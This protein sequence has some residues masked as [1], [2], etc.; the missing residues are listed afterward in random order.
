MRQTIIVI[1]L[2]TTV[3]SVCG[4]EFNTPWIFAPQSDSTSHVY[5]RKSFLS[6]GRP[7]QVALK[8]TTTGYYKL[9]VNECNVGTALFYPHRDGN[10]T[11]AIETTFDITTYLRK[12]TNV[13]AILYSPIYPKLTT[14]QIAVNIY[15]KDCN[16]K[17]FCFISDESWLCRQANSHITPD[18]GEF[19][20][21][22]GHDPSWKAT[23]IY[24]QAL[25]MHAQH[26]NNTHKAMPIHYSEY[27]P[28]ITRVTTFNT[29]DISLTED[30]ITALELPYG[31]YGF[32]RATIREAKRG[33]EIDLGNLHYICNG[34]TDEQ[35]FPQFTINFLRTLPITG[36]DRFKASHIVDLEAISVAQKNNKIR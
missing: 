16:G 11:A 27:S 26:I 36:D 13:I 22:R 29:D 21:G 32:Y 14:K 7:K 33:E 35:A 30:S 17:A 34:K 18:G 1:L 24:N 15:G 28:H 4:Q 12:D 31:F 9:Y 8:F 20:D 23:T 10:D 6:D 3:L 2:F 5:F 19:I 25:W